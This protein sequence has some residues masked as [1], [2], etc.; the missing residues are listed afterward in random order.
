[1]PDI[2]DYGRWHHISCW[3]V[4][5]KIRVACV[6]DGPEIPP[7]EQVRAAFDAISDNV[8]CG[9]ESINPDDAGRIVERVMDAS[10]WA[11][12]PKKKGG[13]G[14]ASAGGVGGAGGAGVGVGG[15][16]AAETSEDTSAALAL[17]PTETSKLVDD[18]PEPRGQLAGKTVVISGVFD[19]PNTRATALA[20]GKDVVRQLLASYG[21]KITGSV[22]RKTDV[23]LCG[24]EP[25]ASRVAQATKLGT[26]I[27]DLAGLKALLQGEEAT[28]VSISTFSTGYRGRGTAL[29]MTDA[30][31]NDLKERAAA[32]TKRLAAEP[33]S[34]APDVEGL[35][36]A[37]GIKKAKLDALKAVVA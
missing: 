17:P 34:A 25:G 35:G 15:S 32:S 16:V 28:P 18:F 1:M 5:Y 6:G 12:A 36:E 9:V 14:T 19:L 10:A 29:A 8:V 11:K 24:V 4:P 2:G 20:Q 27:L 26:Q 37:A 31:L 21:A 23:L 13:D 33:A 22:S 3:R 7:T 30:E